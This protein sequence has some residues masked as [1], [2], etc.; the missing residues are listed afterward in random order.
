MS[1]DREILDNYRDII[2]QGYRRLKPEFVMISEED[3]IEDVKEMM[4][5]EFD[6]YMEWITEEDTEDN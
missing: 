1:M 3:I 4:W 6:S 2:A 5:R